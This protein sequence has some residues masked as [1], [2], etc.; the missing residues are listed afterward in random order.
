MLQNTTE[1]EVETLYRI[2]SP[3]VVMKTRKVHMTMAAMPLP[4]RTSGLVVL[5]EE[6]PSLKG[7]W[8][9]S[10]MVP[11]TLVDFASGQGTLSSCDK[12]RPTAT[13]AEAEDLAEVSVVIVSLTA[14]ADELP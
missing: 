11:M 10:M 8:I 12:A 4:V 9:S 3:A 1:R 6:T 7:P 14:T 5:T 2:D 13:T